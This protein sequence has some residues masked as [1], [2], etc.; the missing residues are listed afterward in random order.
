[1]TPGKTIQSDYK[2]SRPHKELE[3]RHGTS[4]AINNTSCHPDNPQ[5]TTGNVKE[6]TSDGMEIEHLI[7]NV[8]K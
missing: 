6:N 5:I 2:D 1:M 4:V 7:D 3:M 8:Q